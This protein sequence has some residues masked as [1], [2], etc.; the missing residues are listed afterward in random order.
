MRK[1]VSHCEEGCCK[2][3]S[4]CTDWDQASILNMKHF[5][6]I[7]YRYSPDF[8]VSQCTDHSDLEGL[9]W[10]VTVYVTSVLVLAGYHRGSKVPG[11]T[12]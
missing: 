9:N 8:S 1:Q 5:N 10:C 2:T 3:P 12:S 11:S 4:V 7:V 6:C